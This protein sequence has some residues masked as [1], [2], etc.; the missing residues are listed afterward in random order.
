MFV[1]V[2]ATACYSH[3]AVG[4]EEHPQ[5]VMRI[6]WQIYT[7]PQVALGVLTHRHISDTG[8]RTTAARLPT[9]SGRCIGRMG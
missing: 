3:L 4:H 1:Q 7:A 8:G 2:R 5:N 6:L 9:S